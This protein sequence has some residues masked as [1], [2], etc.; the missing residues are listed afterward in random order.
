MNKLLIILTG[1]GRRY[2][3]LFLTIFACMILLISGIIWLCGATLN[4]AIVPVAFVVSWWICKK[5]QGELDTAETLWVSASVLIVLAIISVVC[6]FL[7]DQSYDG[8]WYHQPGIY[9]MSTDWNPIYQHHSMLGGASTADIWITHYCKGQETIIACFLALL[10][11]IEAAKVGNFLLPLAGLFFTVDFLRRNFRDWSKAKTLLLSVA[12]AIQPIAI[13]QMFQTYIDLNLYSIVLIALLN[14]IDNKFESNRSTLLTF[15]LLFFL[16]TA[17]KYNMAMWMVILYF[18]VALRHLLKKEY[19]S[20]G[21]YIAVGLVSVVVAFLTCSFNPYVTN[22]LDHNA[23]FYPV[24]GAGEKNIDMFSAGEADFLKG[25]NGFYK[26]FCSLVMR[27]ISGSMSDGFINPYTQFT[28]KNIVCCA[29]NKLGGGGLFF[30]DILLLSIIVFLCDRKMDSRKRWFCIGY[31]ALV[32]IMMSVIRDGSVWRYS[33]IAFLIPIFM[34]LATEGDR[35]NKYVRWARSLAYLLLV[36]NFLVCS[37]VT[38]GSTVALN[39]VE[40]YYVKAIK[41]SEKDCYYCS[42]WGFN[43]KLGE[44]VRKCAAKP[45][46]EMVHPPLLLFRVALLLD[47]AKLNEPTDLTWMQSQMKKRGMLELK[48]EGKK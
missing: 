14:L 8:I 34:L 15:G 44:D 7:K 45:T 42:L 39:S 30:V 6:Y 9:L 48:E 13:N 11:N 35:L 41:V 18:F 33:S 36:A 10:G 37:V 46:K 25:K 1:G 3:G 26:S 22:T 27:P 23:P 38:I 28:A 40:D 24:I 20:I 2:A 32:L 43:N 47:P 17:I 4:F 29:N 21:K 31:F 5:L 12:I 16:A 19:K